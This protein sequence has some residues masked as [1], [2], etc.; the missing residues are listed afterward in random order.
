MTARDQA[1]AVAPGFPRYFCIAGRWVNSYKVFLCIGIYLGIL[2]SAAAAQA[3]GLS[4]LRVGAG[5]LVCAVIALVGARVYHVA[6][7]L[8][9][10]RAA[11]LGAAIWNTKDGG[12]SIFGALVI[13]PF[14]LSLDSLFGIPAAVLWDHM[15]VGIAFGGAW[16][17]FGCICNGCCVGRESRGWFALRQHD[18]RGV[19]KRRI[20]VEWLEIAWWLIVGLGLI[21]LW[22]ERLPSGCYALGVLGWYG[23]GRFWLEPL[24]EAPELV[25]G[26]VR[27]NQVVAATLATVAGAGLLVIACR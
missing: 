18:T 17:R 5:S 12:W 3:S 24:R 1:L 16:I 8:R 4:A 13:V 20:P 2:V 15:A 25:Y 10:Y 6:V 27:V 14:T 22:P 26:R 23:V 9:A 21:W 7:H 19:S 11:G